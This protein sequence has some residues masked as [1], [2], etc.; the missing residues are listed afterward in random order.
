MLVLG[1]R[2]SGGTFTE[3]SQLYANDKIEYNVDIDCL[4][5][6]HVASGEKNMIGTNP[7]ASTDLDDT[8]QMPLLNDTSLGTFNSDILT[9]GNF[10]AD[11]GQLQLDNGNTYID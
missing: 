10:R 6:I 9:T 5:N 3:Q 7:L 2:D 11:G 8:A 4:E 1:W